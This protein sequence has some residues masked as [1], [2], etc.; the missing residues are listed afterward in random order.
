MLCVCIKQEKAV[1]DLA[2]AA[3][4]DKKKKSNKSGK[5]T[6]LIIYAIRVH[7]F[8][9]QRVRVVK[10]GKLI[11]LPLQKKWTPAS[12]QEVH[13]KHLKTKKI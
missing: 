1:S 11:G 12:R 3:L 8:L 6:S 5:F 13:K 9:Y 10:S 4:A 2:E 7:L